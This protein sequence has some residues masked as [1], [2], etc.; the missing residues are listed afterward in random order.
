MSN[1][2]AIALLLFN[3]LVLLLSH[4]SQAQTISCSV[5]ELIAAIDTA[6]STPEADTL[7][8]SPSC[9]YSFTASN[10]TD[11]NNGDSGL[12][13]ITTPIIIN[14]NDATFERGVSAPDFRYF[15]VRSTGTLTLTNMTLVGGKT[16]GAE[17]SG[18]AIFNQGTLSLID[19]TISDNSAI[20]Q[21]LSQG[22]GLYNAGGMVTITNSTFS[23]NIATTGGGIANSGSGTLTISDSHVSENTASSSGGGIASVNG[24]LTVVIDSTISNNDT[25]ASSEGGGI[26]VSSSTLTV[27]NSTISGNSSYRG[28]GIASNF[29]TVTLINSV[30]SGNKADLA[31]GRGGALHMLGGG[32]KASVINSTISGNN[33]SEGGAI[34]DNGG[35][36]SVNNSIVWG[37]SSAIRKGQTLTV[38]YSLIQG[39]YTGT[40]NLDADPIFVNPV[41]F[42]SAPTTE[43]NYRLQYTSP[44]ISQADS[45]ALPLDTYDLDG[46]SDTADVLPYD[47]DNTL[48]IKYAVLDMGAFEYGTLTELLTN[49]GFEDHVTLPSQ[50]DLWNGTRLSKDSLKCNTGELEF[51]R[52]GSCAFRFSGAAGENA[53]LAQ[54]NT[55]VSGLTSGTVLNAS[56][57]YKTKGAAPKL[58]VM[59]KVYYVGTVQPVVT[60]ATINTASSGDYTL[61]S[62][63]PYVIESGVVSKVRLQFL[64]RAGAGKIYLDDASLGIPPAAAAP[65]AQGL[66]PVPPAP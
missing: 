41:A 62:L 46:D 1:F 38:A 60:K 29:G 28:A 27:V 25:G 56:V 66:I 17:A 39:G 16:T 11:G 49:G 24:A 12:P 54:A 21:P 14:G 42:A 63:A 64:N 61:F 48:R 34:Y 2:K 44:A 43:G 3:T 53:L 22:G 36:V 58:K 6:N 45:T 59:L 65:S 13:F 15:S 55:N 9:I 40:G 20:L 4:S 26:V 50:P 19:S 7:D 18:G 8:L 30:V 5:T 23:G 33:A 10:N 57:Y 32:A 51:S 31:G 52:T 37:N 35:T 47:G